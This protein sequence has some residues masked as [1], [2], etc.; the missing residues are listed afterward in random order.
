MADLQET[1]ANTRVVISPVRFGGGLKIKT[2][3][4][5]AHGRPVVAAKHSV[6]GLTEAI[7]HGLVVTDDWSSFT[8]E[9]NALLGDPEQAGALGRSALDFA[10]AHFSE[11]AVM[12]ELL[13]VMATHVGH[14]GL[15]SAGMTR[16]TS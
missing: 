14:S 9:L 13:E 1:Y 11:A 10:T 3:E 12:R 8:D 15:C 7:G 5:L 16:E 2:I 6:I 4:A